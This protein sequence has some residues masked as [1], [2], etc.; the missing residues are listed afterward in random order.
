LEDEVA[1]IQDEEGIDETQQDPEYI[2]DNDSDLDHIGNLNGKQAKPVT[3]MVAATLSFIFWM[4]FAPS[5]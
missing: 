4:V 5:E 2:D 3:L 1:S